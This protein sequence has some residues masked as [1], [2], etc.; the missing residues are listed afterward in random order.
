MAENELSECPICF[1]NYCDQVDSFKPKLLPCLHSYCTNC[2]SRSISRGGELCCAFCRMP[3]SAESGANSFQNNVYILS[4]LE[5]SK[6]KDKCEHTECAKTV[7]ETQTEERAIAPPV[8][9]NQIRSEL[10]QNPPHLQ[11]YYY[12]DR[13]EIPLPPQRFFDLMENNVAVNQ[14]FRST[15]TTTTTTEYLESRTNPI[16]TENAESPDFLPIPGRVGYFKP[17]PEVAHRYLHSVYKR[18]VWFDGERMVPI[19]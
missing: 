4:Y 11:G 12:P 16:P 15:T 3:H 9:P 7:S 8:A 18:E 14:Y 17:K 1:E 6:H 5:I 13:Y 10:P 19:M 2:I